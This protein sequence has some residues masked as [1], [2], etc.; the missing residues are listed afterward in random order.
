MFFAYDRKLLCIM[1]ISTPLDNSFLDKSEGL[2]RL[3]RGLERLD[4]NGVGLVA[5]RTGV[6]KCQMRSCLVKNKVFNQVLEAVRSMLLKMDDLESFRAKKRNIF[7]K[8]DLPFDFAPVFYE[9][10]EDDWRELVLDSNDYKAK[11]VSYL[12]KVVAKVYAHAQQH[13]EDLCYKKKR[14][15]NHE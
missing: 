13:A 9:W 8:L 4:D 10:V 6:G 12:R 3:R 15:G 14:N 7:S 11:K 2:E 5:V 1:I